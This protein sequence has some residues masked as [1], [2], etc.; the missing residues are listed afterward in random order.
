MAAAVVDDEVGYI[1]AVRRSPGTA[2]AASSW[3]IPRCSSRQAYVERGL[4]DDD[5]IARRPDRSRRA[6]PCPARRSCPAVRRRCGRRSRRRSR[7]ARWRS[8]QRAAS[9]RTRSA[10][11]P[12][13]ICPSSRTMGPNRSITGVRWVGLD[14]QSSRRRNRPRTHP[15]R[16]ASQSTCLTRAPREADDVMWALAGACR[17]TSDDHGLARNEHFPD[18]QRDRDVLRRIGHAPA[19]CRW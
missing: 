9:S 19:Q 4:Y 11:A 5:R 1:A 6:R 17:P 2:R 8:A 15:T 12:R 10:R 3:V 14:D 7:D 18:A 13:S 16:R